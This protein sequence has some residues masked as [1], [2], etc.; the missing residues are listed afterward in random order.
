MT[1]R[2][3]KDLEIITVHAMPRPLDLHQPR[4]RGFLLHADGHIAKQDIAQGAADYQGGA[5]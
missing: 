4:V 1:H 3:L 2:S 5:G